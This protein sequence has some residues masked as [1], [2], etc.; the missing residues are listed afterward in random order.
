[1]DERGATSNLL[2]YLK[3]LAQLQEL[4]LANTQ[5]TD[6]GLEHLKSLT[7]LQMLYLAGPR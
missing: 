2:A 6:I 3:D 7:Q 5:V 4:R 1:M